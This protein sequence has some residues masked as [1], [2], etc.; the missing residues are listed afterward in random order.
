VG[1]ADGLRLR[2]S[3]SAGHFDEHPLPNAA[4]R[5]TDEA[6]VDG[7]VWTIFGRTVDPATA[8][9]QNMQ[10]AADN[11]P[12]IDP[13]IAAH[14]NRQE[15]LDLRPLLVTQPKHCRSRSPF[16]PGREAKNVQQSDS[17]MRLLGFDPSVSDP[18][19]ACGS[20][21]LYFGAP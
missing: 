4:L 20:A 9:F 15:R 8:T 2:H 17:A 6:I 16:H 7:R 1:G 14:V 13:G 11:S 18:L 5:P 21:I 3:P 12:V 19:I 10:N